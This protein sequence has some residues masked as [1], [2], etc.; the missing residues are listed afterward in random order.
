MPIEA[1]ERVSG[2]ERLASRS[3][4]DPDLYGRSSGD[5]QRTAHKHEPTSGVIDFNDFDDIYVAQAL[6][7]AR[8][9]V[10]DVAVKPGVSRDFAD[11]VRDWWD[12]LPVPIRK[13]A[14]EGSIKVIL[15]DN[16]KQVMPDADKRQTRGHALGETYTM[17]PGFYYP[18]KNAVV[19]VQHH[20]PTPGSA[21]AQELNARRGVM[22]L[23][24]STFDKA[25]AWHELGHALDY[26]ALQHLSG[27]AEFKAAYD[28][29]CKMLPAGEQAMQR[30][31]LQPQ[32]KP[33]AREELF[34]ELFWLGHK[35]N[36]L[37]GERRKMSLFSN[38]VELMR[39]RQL[40]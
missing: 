3:L 38:V 28:A 5:L 40:I 34:A 7:S 25:I 16:A 13:L 8:D 35:P 10:K 9:S 23:S 12:S 30:Y 1:M 15:A 19:I 21:R 14:H 27:S 33:A 32:N 29:D 20:D 36:L 2:G 39:K 24:A 18:E 4:L 11:R 22:D 6:P 26:T 37:D 31:Y 17:Q